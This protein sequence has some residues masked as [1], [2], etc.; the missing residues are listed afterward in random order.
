M[1]KAAKN[2][3]VYFFG[4]GCADGKAAMKNLLGGKGANLAEM[5]NLGIPVPPGFTISTEVCTSFYA[6]NKKFPQDLKEEVKITLAKVEKVMQ[7]RFGDKHNPLL[8]SVRSGART[9]MPGMM[10]S[11]LNL[12]LNDE[13]I[14]GLITKIKNERT[15]YDSYRRFMMMYANVV[16]GLDKDYFEHLL[17]EKKKEK[18]VKLDPELTAQDLKELIP[19][20][21]MLVEKKSNNPFPQDAQEQL[22]GAIGAVFNSWHNKRAITYRRLNKIPDNWGTAVN[23]QT[24]VFG[25]MGNDSATGVAFTRDPATGENVFYGEYLVNAQGEDVV[26]GVRT[27]HPLNKIQKQAKKIKLSSLE[28]ELPKAYRELEGIRRKLEKHYRDMQDI[29]FTIQKGKLWMLQTRTGK[30]TALSSIRIAV[31]MAQEKLIT[32]Q[33]AVSRVEPGQLDQILHRMFDPQAKKDVLAKGLPASPGAASGRVVFSA[34][35]AEQEVTISNRVILVRLETSPEDIHGMVAAE[36]ILTARGGMTS[37]AAVVAR[38]MGKCCV[39][40]C[41]AIKVDYN[42]GEFSVGDK[43][44]KKDD[45]ISIDGTSGE[46]MRGEVST[47][48]SEITQVIKGALAADKSSVYK[49]YEQL[50]QW[51]EQLKRLG[52]RANADTPEDAKIARAFGA[53]GIGLCRTEH[54]FFGE[55]RLPKVRRMIL[56]DTEAERSQALDELLPY[57]REDFRGILKAMDG[58]PVIIR[59]L[60]PP[61]H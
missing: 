33:E 53:T 26:A 10:D 36:G 15:A 61:L 57:Q 6:N 56:A 51:V 44:I 3:M 60:D 8:V 59:L 34:D 17:E 9:S 23:V 50:M 41:E 1:T 7:A 55:E 5:T 45:Y 11:V 58:L 13:T 20:Y 30:R 52:V 39:A 29:E 4:A 37:H 28:E 40:G 49:I 42:R 48:D 24:M 27:P 22:W 47:V 38:G 25:N 12:G 54:M 46:V 18:G 43:I 14:K 16:L 19:Q 35:E 2:K 32:K 21:K 31:E